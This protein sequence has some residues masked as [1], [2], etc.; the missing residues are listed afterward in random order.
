MLRSIMMILAGKSEEKCADAVRTRQV[1]QM[2][3][4]VPLIAGE[5]KF[6]GRV[7]AIGWLLPKGR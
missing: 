3:K 4:Y 5:V 7:F 2:T 6:A 1:V